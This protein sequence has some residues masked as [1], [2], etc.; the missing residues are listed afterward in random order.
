M[1][2]AG[3]AVKRPAGAA[4][5]EW[6]QTP[7]GE[8]ILEG[9]VGGL[10]A[11]LPM[12]FVQDQDPGA[13]A[14]MTAGGVLGGIGVGMAGRKIGAHL[15]KHF[16]PEA[17]KDQDGVIAA[18]ART[19]GSE[20]LTQGLEQQ[21]RMMRGQVADYLV[22]RQAMDM[23]REGRVSPELMEELRGIRQ[24]SSAVDA[25]R[26]MTP[27]QRAG[28]FGQTGMTPEKMERLS[29]LEKELTTGAAEQ[30]DRHLMEAAE[31]LE[32]EGSAIPVLTPEM[33]RGM[34]QPPEA[35]TGEHVGR[36]IGRVA[37]DEIGVLGGIGLG[38][39]LASQLG[40]QSP[41]DK[42]IARLKQQ[43]GQG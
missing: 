39:L 37:G 3:V 27:E 17:L 26:G 20:S 18:L 40:V 42:E 41:K 31:L 36:M 16:H 34:T 28:L 19:T 22:E 25:L 21:G 9:T 14:L 5:L 8:E 32:R 23:V 30:M 24:V 12:F 35:V 11:G 33:L 15:G 29:Q 38:G 43:L 7:M 1:V 6:A 2:V 4:L 10:I 13:A